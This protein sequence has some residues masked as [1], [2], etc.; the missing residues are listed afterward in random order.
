MA[1]TKAELQSDATQYREALSAMRQAHRESRFLDAINIAMHACD[2]VDGMMQFERRFEERSERRSV[3]TIDYVLQYAPLVFDRTNLEALGVILKSQKRIDKNTTAD[4]AENLKRANELMWDAHR[5][6][7]VLE[8]AA[9]T[10]QDKL[11]ANLGGD[12]DSWRG[13]AESWDRMGLIERTPVR[14]SYRISLVTRITTEIRGKCPACGATG[15]A[16]M[17]RF[18]EEITCPKCKATSVFVILPAAD[19]SAK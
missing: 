2:Y 16:A 18:L 12:Q 1:K 13:I 15:K 10:P 19:Q 3:E 14:G 9:D 4:L 7:T 11:R 6:W 5:L 17:G 8:Q